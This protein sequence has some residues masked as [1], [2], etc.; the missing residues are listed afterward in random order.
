[1][2]KLRSSKLKTSMV[3]EQKYIV[4][5]YSGVNKLSDMKKINQNTLKQMKQFIDLNKPIRIFQDLRGE[6]KVTFDIYEE[7]LKVLNIYEIDRIAIVHSDNKFITA[8]AKNTVDTYQK[9]IKYKLFTDPN[10]AISWL[11]Q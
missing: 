7:A 8:M 11:N 10:E 6:F 2:Q 1:M 9:F 3:K 4:R 5:S